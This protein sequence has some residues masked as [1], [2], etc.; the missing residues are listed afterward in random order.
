MQTLPTSC[1]LRPLVESVRHDFLGLFSN[2]RL[3]LQY[4]FRHSHHS[5]RNGLST[6]VEYFGV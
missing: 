4:P 1:T 6:Y 5:H 3:G 2:K